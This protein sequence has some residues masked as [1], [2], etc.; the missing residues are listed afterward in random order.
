MGEIK[1]C[2][3]RLFCRN[4][5]TRQIPRFPPR[6]MDAIVNSKVFMYP[7]YLPRIPFTPRQRTY[8]AFAP[9]ESQLIAMGLE[10]HMKRI[11]ETN[12]KVYHKTT[13]LRL[14]CKRLCRDMVWGKNYRRVWEHI[15]NLKKANYYNPIKVS[16]EFC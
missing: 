15:M 12:E 13:P 5:N 16:C 10:K 1:I 14:A 11:T 6:V 9:A 7:Q 8:E 3:Y 2:N 4:K